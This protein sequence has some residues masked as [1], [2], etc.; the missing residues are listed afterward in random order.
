MNISI[1][2]AIAANNAIGKDNDLLWHI[3]KDLKRFKQLTDG[4]FIVMGKRTYF[5]LPKRPLPNRTNMVITD[6]PGEQID[7]CL[8]AYSIEDA[9]EKMDRESENFIIGGGSIYRQFIPYADK[10]YITRVFKEFEAD[11]FFPE[12]PLN[13][14]KLTEKQV[15]N[16]DP[17][18]DFTYSFEIYERKKK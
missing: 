7:D 1:I 3:S 18:N 11:T 13:E 5:S 4:H 10:L 17:Q 14:W 8:M 9:I 16:D 15:V 2:V 6:V 12:I